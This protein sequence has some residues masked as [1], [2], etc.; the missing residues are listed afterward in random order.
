MLGKFALCSV[1]LLAMAL[2][3]Y[4]DYVI[5]IT[6]HQGL[7]SPDQ[8]QTLD[9]AVGSSVSFNFDING[10][11]CQIT[12]TRVDQELP[13]CFYVLPTSFTTAGDMFT[14]ASSETNGIFSGTVSRGCANLGINATP[15]TGGGIGDALLKD[16]TG[17]VGGRKRER[18]LCDQGTTALL[19]CN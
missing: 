9:D 12:W 18:D 11:N 19:R 14:I 6:D 7:T 13:G 4:G 1:S 3:V 8:Q 5:Q 16:C 10:G 17:G 2:P 15:R